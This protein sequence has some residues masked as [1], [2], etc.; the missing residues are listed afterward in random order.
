MIVTIPFFPG[1][2]DYGKLTKSINSH[3]L[4]GGHR[5]LVIS[6]REDEE[7]AMSFEESI[8]E[9]FAGSTHRVVDPPREPGKFGVA[10]EIFRQSLAYL[11][12]YEPEPGEVSDVTLLYFDPLLRPSK[13]GWADAI[14]S[15]YFARGCPQVLSCQQTRQDGFKITWGAVLFNK[16]YVNGSALLPHLPPTDFWREYLRHE[17]NRGMVVSE[18]L[19]PRGPNSVVGQ[20]NNRTPAGEAKEARAKKKAAT[21]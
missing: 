18:T 20:T 15:E 16:G 1:Y 13:K 17:L 21:A 3:G 8:S 6:R 4:C 19:F 7:A 10:N 9:M 12:R 14:Q 11:K 2:T 5:L